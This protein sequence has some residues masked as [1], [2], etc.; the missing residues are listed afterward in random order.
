MNTHKK[1]EK[2]KAKCREIIALGE[3]RTPGAWLSLAGVSVNSKDTAIQIGRIYR[4]GGNAA[5]FARNLERQRNDLLEALEAV[6]TTEG[7]NLD[8]WE[9]QAFDMARA[10]IAKAKGSHQ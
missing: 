5:D 7:R 2:I 9:S 6:L 8:S 10:A 1:L 4:E 3:R